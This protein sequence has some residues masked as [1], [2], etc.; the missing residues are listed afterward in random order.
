MNRA[1]LL[2][3]VVGCEPSRQNRAEDFARGLADVHRWDP[4]RQAQGF[5]AYDELMR[6]GD[7]AIPALL[8]RLT[9]DTQTR[10]MDHAHIAVP[11][12]GDVC[13]QMLLKLTGMRAEEFASDGVVV[14]REIENP[15]FAVRFDPGAR[16]RVQKR[17]RKLVER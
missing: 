12:V 16:L 13:F 14:L 4:L 5:Y 3:L 15:I 1:L 10:I 17:F 6:L 11:V 7:E 8:A 2:L 9:D